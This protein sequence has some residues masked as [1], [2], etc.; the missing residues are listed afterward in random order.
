MNWT[1]NWNWR[2]HLVWTCSNFDM[3]FEWQW[4]IHW[5]WKWNRYWIEL[6]GNWHGMTLN[7]KLNCQLRW[8]ELETELISN[9]GLKLQWNW[10]V[11]NSMEL[12]WMELNWN[13]FEMKWIEM[14]WL[15]MNW[16]DWINWIGLHWHWIDLNWMEL[17]QIKL[18]FR[19][20]WMYSKLLRTWI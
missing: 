1:R 20:C 17:D 8:I 3:P 6:N 13:W 14:N 7:P 5:I 12:G 16:T 10:I 9:K 4:H 15:D 11:C 2:L 19:R 18:K